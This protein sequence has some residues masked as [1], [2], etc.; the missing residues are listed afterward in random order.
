MLRWRAVD[1]VLYF[2]PVRENI[3]AEWWI[4]QISYNIKRGQGVKY[5]FREQ[6]DSK[7]SKDG[8]EHE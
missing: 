4:S 2:P 3:Q 7:Q 1:M 5:V 8:G 6:L